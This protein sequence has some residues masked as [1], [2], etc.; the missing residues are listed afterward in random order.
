MTF[1]TSLTESV[2]CQFLPRQMQQKVMA[3]N[4]GGLL[5]DHYSANR[6]YYNILSNNWYWDRMYTD[7]VD[8]EFRKSCTIVSGGERRVKCYK[9]EEYAKQLSIL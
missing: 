8:L 4:H 7:A 1:S 3:E 2:G 5:G 6:L 9:V